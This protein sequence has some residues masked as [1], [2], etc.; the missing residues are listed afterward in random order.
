MGSIKS[1]KTDNFRFDVISVGNGFAQVRVSALLGDNKMGNVLF[2]FDGLSRNKPIA[3]EIAQLWSTVEG[4]ESRLSELLK[5][6]RP[7]A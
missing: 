1:I 3:V 5:L 4:F 7:A 6:R 2:S